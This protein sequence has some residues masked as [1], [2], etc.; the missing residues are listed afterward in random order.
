MRRKGNSRAHRRARIEHLEHRQL[1]SVAP[2]AGQWIVKF[3]GLPGKG[4]GQIN[5]L[6]QLLAKVNK[7]SH[8]TKW[9]GVDGLALLKAP[10]TLGK[11]A[12]AGA[13]SKIPGFALLEP[14]YQVSIQ[15]TV[16]DPSFGSLWGLNNTGQSAG[17][18]DADIDAPEAW[19]LQKGN[20]TVVVGDIDTGID[21]NHPDLKDAIYTNPGEIAGNAK[22][23]DNNGYID[24]VHGWDFYNNDNDPQ[25][26]N[27]HGS[28][29]RHDRRDAEQ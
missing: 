15:A 3:N 22:D 26:D 14:D 4:A 9:L 19:D 11:A 8:A 27:D 28:H 7:D 12:L 10:A 20:G 2:V 16:N 1:L 6:N 13:L 29:R 24:D 25:D 5:A 23:D 17:T 18:A 21:F